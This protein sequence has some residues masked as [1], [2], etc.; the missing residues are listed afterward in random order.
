MQ[1]SPA[2][3]AASTLAGSLRYG[4]AHCMGDVQFLCASP[5][6]LDTG[7]RHTA[8]FARWTNEFIRRWSQRR[9]LP[10]WAINGFGWQFI[11]HNKNGDVHTCLT[12]DSG[13][14]GVRLILN[15]TVNANTMSVACRCH[16][17]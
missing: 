10:G 12:S 11:V 4:H 8:C 13:W 9:L 17:Q 7:P 6:V 15:I 1:V 5:S 2:S 14:C 3:L 16:Q